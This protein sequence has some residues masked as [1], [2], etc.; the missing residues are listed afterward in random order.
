MVSES[1]VTIGS[2]NGLS[3]DLH[4]S[5][6]WTNADWRIVNSTAVANFSKIE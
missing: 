3:T 6:T 5:I 4:H 2:S 1:L